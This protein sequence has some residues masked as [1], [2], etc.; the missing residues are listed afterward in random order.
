MHSMHGT[1]E[2][3]NKTMVTMYLRNVCL[4]VIIVINLDSPI[5]VIKKESITW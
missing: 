4:D 1:K 5:E 3:R 2:K